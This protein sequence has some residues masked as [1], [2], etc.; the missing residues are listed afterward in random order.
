MAILDKKSLL[1]K[2]QYDK[3]LQK[4]IELESYVQK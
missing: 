1:S 2:S 4:Q 3:T